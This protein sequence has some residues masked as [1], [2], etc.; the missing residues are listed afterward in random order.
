MT[1]RIVK[2]IEGKTTTIRVE[3]RLDVE[4]VSD[5]QNECRLCRSEGGLAL[6]LSGL[7]SADAE[8]L[9]VLRELRERG[10][11]LRGISPFIRLLLDRRSRR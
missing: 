5:L 4:T 3:G 6:D 11:E 1:I 9:E 2:T 8:G 7:V 10:I